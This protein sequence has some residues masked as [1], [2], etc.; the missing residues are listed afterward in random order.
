MPPSSVAR[1]FAVHLRTC[2]KSL[3]SC[4]V[5]HFF[6]LARTRSSSGRNT[7]RVVS[8]AHISTCRR[9]SNYVDHRRHN[10]RIADRVSTSGISVLWD[11]EW[12]VRFDIKSCSN[13]DVRWRS[14][15]PYYLCVMSSVRLSPIVPC[16]E[17]TGFFSRYK[18]IGKRILVNSFMWS[19]HKP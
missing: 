7:S 13:H 18:F 8:D 4:V 11:S 2:S 5:P 1:W 6:T 16:V 10:P 9:Y 14:A 19:G 15:L 12:I 17:F 3:H